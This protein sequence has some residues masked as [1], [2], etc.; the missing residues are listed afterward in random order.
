MT[1]RTEAP[2]AYEDRLCLFL[3]ILGFKNIVAES[4]QEKPETTKSTYR[5]FDVLR[6]HS[7]LSA[8]DRSIKPSGPTFGGISKSSKQVTQFS[9][10]IVVSYKLE[11]KS[12][13]FDMLYDMYFLQIELVQRGILVRG[14]I[15][16]GQLFH[17]KQIVFGPALVEAAELEKLAMYPRVI[18]HQEIIDHGKRRYASHHSSA[19]EENSIRSMLQQDLDGMFFI[20]Y[21]NISPDD[22]DEGWDGLYEYLISLREMVRRLSH[23]TQNPSIKLKHSWMRQKFNDV[24]R[25][26]EQSK[27]KSLNKSYV[28]DDLEDHIRNISPFR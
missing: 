21:F 7:A 24:A 27:Y 2:V 26:L 4:T 5:R 18:L 12:A 14:A 23:L 16:S 3:D 1:K 10:S 9:D 25:K 6:I 28:P 11:E 22:F 8:I 15:T 13:V 17:D 20:D 19:D